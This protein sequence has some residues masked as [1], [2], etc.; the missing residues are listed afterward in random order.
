M[1]N[2]AARVGR[3]HKV[4]VVIGHPNKII[5]LFPVLEYYAV[6]RGR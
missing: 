3:D 4:D 2:M 5:F 1:M 6:G